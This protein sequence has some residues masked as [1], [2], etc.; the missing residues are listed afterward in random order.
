MKERA[1][2]IN[3]S[4][5]QKNHFA[6]AEEVT[7]VGKHNKRPDIV[8]YVNGIAIGIL[9]L[10][11]SKTGVTQGIRQNLDNQKEEFIPKFF[12]AAQL[13]FAGNDTRATLRYY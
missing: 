4:E 2:F 7:V 9:E 11:R 12:T 1:W 8:I 6:I 13:V 5:P 3:W 10:K